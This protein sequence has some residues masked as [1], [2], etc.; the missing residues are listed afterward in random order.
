M[1]FRG[2]LG[3]R[4][5]SEE[6]VWPAALQSNW[7]QSPQKQKDPTMS[8]KSYTIAHTICN[9]LCISLYHTTYHILVYMFTRPF[10]PPSSELP[11]SCRSRTLP[12]PWADPTSRSTLALRVQVVRKLMKT[13]HFYLGACEYGMGQVFIV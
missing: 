3:A 12:E 6:S 11:F 10:E 8:Y 1:A 4:S 13:L 5:K 2:Y 9:I 7:P